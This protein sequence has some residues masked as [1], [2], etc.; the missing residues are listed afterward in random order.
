MVPNG[1][2]PG[3]ASGI[4]LESLASVVT[5]AAS[6]SVKSATTCRVCA[7]LP[8]FGFYSWSL[9]DKSAFIVIR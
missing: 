8:T 9:E 6:K 2:S 3:N 7:D 1:I 5:D 4:E